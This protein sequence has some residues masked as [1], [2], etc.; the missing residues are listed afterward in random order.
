MDPRI[1][2]PRLH[3]IVNGRTRHGHSHTGTGTGSQRVPVYGI[4]GS[5][6]TGT[7]YRQRS[8]SKV[9]CPVGVRSHATLSLVPIEQLLG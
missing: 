3:V 2:D 1:L 4:D 9:K 6:G 5:T 7:L 8:E